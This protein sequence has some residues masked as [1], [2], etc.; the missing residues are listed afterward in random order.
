MY[1]ADGWTGLAFVQASYRNLHVAGIRT[2]L[3]LT[4]SFLQYSLP[5]YL[6]EASQ[7][8]NVFLQQAGATLEWDWWLTAGFKAILGSSEFQENEWIDPS[9]Y[10]KHRVPRRLRGPFVSSEADRHQTVPQ[11]YGELIWDNL[12]DEYGLVTG[13]PLEGWRVDWK[14]LAS[15]RNGRQEGYSR[16]FFQLERFLHVAER[17]TVVCSFIGRWADRTLPMYAMQS[18]GGADYFPDQALRGYILSY[19]WGDW[20]WNLSAEWRFPLV[21]SGSNRLGGVAYVDSGGVG[22]YVQAE[23]PGY[24]PGPYVGGGV[25]IRYFLGDLIILRLDL[26]VPRVSPSEG[27]HDLP[28]NFVH[29]GLGQTF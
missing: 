7:T 12:D 1:S 23:H 8:K 5:F 15:R 13:N 16:T 14:W 19:L 24:D 9:P 17:Q 28:W 25:G 3:D 18:Y 26:A 29:V 20:L 11:F 10:L 21:G 27:P 4:P 22:A 6:E 2:E